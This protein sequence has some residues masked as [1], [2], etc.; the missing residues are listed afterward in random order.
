MSASPRTLAS[1]TLE[2]KQA[3]P[4]LLVNL[5]KKAIFCPTAVFLKIFPLNYPLR[6]K[7]R[8]GPLTY[9]S[10]GAASEKVKFIFKSSCFTCKCHVDV[11]VTTYHI[12]YNNNIFK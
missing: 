11:Y 5:S 4:L 6:K 2:V 10:V 3:L 7:E 9:G 12:V 8:N 1:N